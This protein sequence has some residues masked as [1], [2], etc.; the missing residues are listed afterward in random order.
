M[1]IMTAIA[2]VSHAL[3]AAKKLREIEKDFDAAAYKLQVAELA[4]T[5]AD[6]KLALT[7]I[8]GEIVAKGAEISRLTG[9]LRFQGECV[10]RESFQFS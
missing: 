1:D 10:I 5:L 4:S 3:D 7:E 8:R 9:A 6:A 2:A